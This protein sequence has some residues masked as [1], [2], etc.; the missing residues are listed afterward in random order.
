[1]AKSRKLSLALGVF[2]AIAA[3][4]AVRAAD[5]VDG[6]A[7]SA[8]PSADITDVFAWMSSD[9]TKVYLVMDLVR[10]ASPSSKFSDSVQ[11]VFHTKSRQSFGADAAPEVDVICTFDAAQVVQCW[12]G[13]DAYVTGDAS[14]VDGIT[15]SDGKLRVFTGLRNDPFFF[16]LQ[17]FRETARTV[18]AAAGGLTFDAAGCPAVDAATSA[19]L[20]DKLQ[21]AP[22]GS[23]AVDN[24]A[25]F[26][27]LALVVVV[28]KSILDGGGP[29]LAVSA[30]TRRI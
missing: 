2:A 16:N 13:D 17:G 1:M 20:V 19:L 12:A 26:N 21:H 18:T 25:N 27:V 7:A 23:P 5:H 30:S 28:D 29:I 15:S 14:G 4:P 8:D 3:A 10:N 6:P 22:D 11:Y 9:A 24:F